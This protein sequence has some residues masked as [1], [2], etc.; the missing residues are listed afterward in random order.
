VYGVGDGGI[1]SPTTNPPG[2]VLSINIGGNMYTRRHYA[3]ILEILAGLYNEVETSNAPPR[4][5]IER[6][7]DR[8]GQHFS[9]DNDRF[10]YSRYTG[11][12]NKLTPD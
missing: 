12:W 1:H 3:D 9:Q 8:L 10:D 4:A 7:V 11:Y 6:V 5:I 2:G